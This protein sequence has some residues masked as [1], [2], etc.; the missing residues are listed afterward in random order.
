MD[1]IAEADIYNLIGEAGFRQ[2][3]EAFYRRVPQDPVLGPMYPADDLTAAQERLT[4]FLIQRF[5]GPYTYSE[6]RGHPRLR[7]RHA[8]FRI[9]LRA[10]DHW[11]SI[12]TAAMNEVKIDKRVQA[13]LLPYFVS[14]AHG[15]MNTVD[16]EERE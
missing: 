4:G 16:T 6:Q 11:L 12:M 7:M 15:M 9:G 8:P 5:G 10:R 1:P 2:L 3:V 14:T 13:V